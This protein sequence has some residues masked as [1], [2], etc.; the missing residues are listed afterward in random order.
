MSSDAI[1]P[2]WWMQC[3]P[4]INIWSAN[5]TT[6]TFTDAE[7]QLRCTSHALGTFPI[8][9]EP[10]LVDKTTEMT[11]IGCLGYLWVSTAGTADIDWN[12]LSV[13]TQQIVRAVAISAESTAALEERIPE[14][15]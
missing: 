7:C 11:S 8:K 2:N 14:E 15:Y 10:S 13:G 4:P 5:T 3:H 9:S 1:L 12:V 6:I